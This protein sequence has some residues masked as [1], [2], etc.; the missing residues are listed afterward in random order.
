MRSIQQDMTFKDVYEKNGWILNITVTNEKLAKLQICN[1]LTTPDVLLWSACCAS[2][3]VPE[4]FG[5]NELFY[6]DKDGQIQPYYPSDN[7]DC[8]I[9]FI[10]G[11]LSSDIPCREIG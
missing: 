7:G 1:Y 2:C 6:K 3:S 11:S 9:R 10:D 8:G 4:L 5:S